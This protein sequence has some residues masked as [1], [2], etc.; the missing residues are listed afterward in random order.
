MASAVRSPPTGAFA[1]FLR[2]LAAHLARQG[3]AGHR[4]SITLVGHSMGAIILN[5]ALALL[6]S[7][8]DALGEIPIEDVIY[9]APACSIEEAAVA[10][11][12][13]LAR[14][15]GCRFHLMTLHPVAEADEMGVYGLVPRGSLLE[16]IDNYYTSPTS[17]QDRRLGK[18]ANVMQAVH[19]FRDVASRVTIKAFGVKD[20]SIPQAHGDFNLC[21]FWRVD[22]R[23]PTG[24]MHYPPDWDDR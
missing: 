7:E 10:I 20:D 18:W 6:G 2:L 24:A 14:R 8:Q 22:F 17:P 13:Y 15:P 21:P 12:G 9:M 23:D 11:V 16:W 5:D 1:V 19:L 3:A 4:Y